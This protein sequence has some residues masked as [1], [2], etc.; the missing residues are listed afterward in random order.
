MWLD[1]VFDVLMLNIYIFLID[2]KKTFKIMILHDL[3][4]LI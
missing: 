4:D 1:K 3:N 2:L